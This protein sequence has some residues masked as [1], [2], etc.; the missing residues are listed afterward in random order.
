MS[1]TKEWSIISSLQS[2]KRLAILKTEMNGG[3]NLDLFNVCI[4]KVYAWFLGNR[5]NNE[6]ESAEVMSKHIRGCLFFVCLCSMVW[7]EITTGTKNKR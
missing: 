4:S 7:F 1:I 3:K 6:N 2:S 5:G